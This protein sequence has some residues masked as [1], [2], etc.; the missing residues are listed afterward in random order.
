MKRR[1][2]RQKRRLRPIHRQPTPAL[3]R[4]TPDHPPALTIP[5]HPAAGVSN[6]RL[7]MGLLGRFMVHIIFPVWNGIGA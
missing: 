5:V 4:M 2:R 1:A 3:R 7:G 6:E